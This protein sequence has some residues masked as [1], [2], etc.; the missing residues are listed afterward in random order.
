[1][2]PVWQLRDIS[3]DLSNPVYSYIVTLDFL[4][5]TEQNTVSELNKALEEGWN[6]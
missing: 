3:R 2:R 6:N 1:M 5:S 4:L